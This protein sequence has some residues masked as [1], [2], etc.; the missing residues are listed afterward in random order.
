M[1]TMPPTPPTPPTQHAAEQSG[2]FTREELGLAA[3]NHGMPLEA[4]AWDVTPP[5]LHYLL[6]HYDVPVVD[7]TDWRLEL[8]GAVRRPLALSLP[9]LMERPHVTQRVTLEC[10]GNGRALTSPRPASQPWLHGAVGTAE[11]TGTPLGPLLAEAGLEADALDVVFTGLD[12]GVEGGV[13]Q[14]YARSLTIEEATEGEALLVW[15]MNGAE[16]PPQHGAPLRLVVPGWYGMASVKWLTR[17]AAVREP[18]QGYQQADA[19]VLRRTEDD[20]GV[21]LTR[22][23]VRSLLVPPG[24]PDFFARRRHVTG[25]SI[26]L[27]GRAWSG[28]GPVTRVEISDDGGTTWFDAHVDPRPARYAWQSFRADWTPSAAEHELCCRATDAAG[29]AQPLEPVWSTG[30]YAQNAVQRIAVGVIDAA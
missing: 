29:A 25:G 5:G 4:L 10:A 26:E 17:I 7:V 12:R 9:E 1:P 19:Y 14:A 21:P 23:A 20:P 30:G 2:S 8:G 22:L 28:S 27:R 3:R 15:S 18:F 24:I 11:W 13:A 6:V 16:L